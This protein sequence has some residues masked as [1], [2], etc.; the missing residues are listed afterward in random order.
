MHRWIPATPS[1]DVILRDGDY[2]TP[3]QQE[4]TL[5]PTIDSYSVDLTLEEFDKVSLRLFSVLSFYFI[6]FFFFFF[7]FL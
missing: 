3:S 2:Q 4:I 7:F 1:E 5:S 6:F